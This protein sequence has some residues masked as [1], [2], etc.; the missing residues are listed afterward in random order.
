MENFLHPADEDTD[1]KDKFEEYVKRIF[2]YEKIAD[3]IPI[4][5]EHVIRMG[6]Y[7]VHREGL[8]EVLVSSAEALQKR[9]IDHCTQL[10]QTRCR[11]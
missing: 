8:V 7:E 1:D 9:L 2:E 5:T 11:M 4:A 6:M 3:E 10:Y